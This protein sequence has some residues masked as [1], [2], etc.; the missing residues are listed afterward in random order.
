M[1]P[2]VTPPESK[3]TARNSL[4]TK[5]EKVSIPIYKTINKLESSIFRMIRSAAI[6]RKIPTP[7]ATVKTSVLLGTEG[8]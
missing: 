2:V 1:G 6:A 5:K 3:A 4:G 7:M 8:T